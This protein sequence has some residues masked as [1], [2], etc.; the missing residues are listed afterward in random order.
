MNRVKLESVQCIKDLDVTIVS[1]LKFSQQCK[2]AAGKANRI[3]GFINKNFF[4]IKDI[5]LPLY[6]SLVRPHL[7]YA[8]HLV[9]SP[10]QG[11]C[12]TRS[13][14]VQ[15]RATKM[16]A[17][18]CNKSYKERLAPLNLFSPEKR[19][20]WEKLLSVL[21]YLKGLQTWAKANCSQLI[22][23]HVLGTVV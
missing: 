18:L 10:S 9:A 6:I 20:F 15:W 22:I 5:I 4:K 11:Y 2:N 3:L 19:Q 23:H 13:L 7:E 16:I 17:S 8:V 1:S 14:D 12:K 21:K